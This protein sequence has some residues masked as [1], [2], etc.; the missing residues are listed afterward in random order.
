MDGLCYIDS[1]SCKV[2]DEL[3][4]NGRSLCRSP[5]CSAELQ[6]WRCIGEFGPYILQEVVTLY[7]PTSHTTEM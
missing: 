6:Q 7:M 5:A 2:W 1:V 3:K 4:S